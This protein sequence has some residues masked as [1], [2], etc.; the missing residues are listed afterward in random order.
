MSSDLKGLVFNIQRFSVHDGPGIRTTVFMKG[1]PLSCLWCS[2]PESQDFDAQ[3]MTR[4]IKCSGCGACEQVCPQAAIRIDAHGRHIDWDKCDQCLLCAGVC[5]YGALAQSGEK[6]TIEEVLEE[7]LSD[8]LFYKNSGGGVTVSGGEPL[9]QSDFVAA[10]LKACKKEG[11]HTA[12]DTTGYVSWSQIQQVAPLADLMLWDIKQLDPETHRKGTRVGNRLIL[13]NIKKAS[14][15]TSIWIRIPLI[16]GYNDSDENINGVI[17]LAQESGVR[18]ISLLPYHEGGRTKHE[19]IGR[20]YPY[21]GAC[22]PAPERVAKL[23]EMIE[24]KG[25]EAGVGN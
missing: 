2:N 20:A 4:D 18:K 16:A 1:C 11:L 5:Q 14:C 3:L 19:Q 21:S 7:V 8:R 6:K 23:A 10:L 12:V 15:L 9:V 25:I 24:K 22:E 17:K 13:E